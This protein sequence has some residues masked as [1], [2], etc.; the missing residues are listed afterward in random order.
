VFGCE[1]PSLTITDANK[2][3]ASE[4]KVF[5]TKMGIKTMT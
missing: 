5:R 3:H 4:N 2:F 1:T